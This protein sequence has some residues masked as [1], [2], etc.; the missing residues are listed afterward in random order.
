MRCIFYLDSI[1][2]SGKLESIFP[3]RQLN[4]CEPECPGDKHLQPG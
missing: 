2:E 3:T 4:L 1:I